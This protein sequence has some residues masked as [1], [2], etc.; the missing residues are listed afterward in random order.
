MATDVVCKMNVNEKVAAAKR[1]HK[2]KTF[3]FCSQKCAETFD[4]NPAQFVQ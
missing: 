3:Y 1:E 4:K 2:G